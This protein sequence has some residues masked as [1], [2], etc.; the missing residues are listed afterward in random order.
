M[1]RTAPVCRMPHVP[2]EAFYFLGPAQSFAPS[3]PAP[4]GGATAPALPASFSPEIVALDTAPA[5]V[6]L[7][8][9]T[10]PFDAYTVKRDFPILQEKVHGKP[11]RVAR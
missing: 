9:A 5:A 11:P 1:C 6:D 8:S 10:R 2:G 3:E 4:Q 7:G